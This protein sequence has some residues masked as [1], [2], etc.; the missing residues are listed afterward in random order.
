[1]NDVYK[2]YRIVRGQKVSK[3]KIEFARSLRKNMSPVERELWCRLRNGQ[4]NGFKFRRQQIVGCFIADFYCHSAA[5]A[6]EIDG[7]THTD[8]SY[9][10]ARDRFF[11]NNGIRVLR[12][13]NQQ[14]VN[15]LDAVVEE[16]FRHLPL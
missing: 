5:L 7:D 6:V 13:T 1:M 9:D 2:P 15:E 11:E 8:P 16:I 14:V 10:G 4:L 3:Q 12:F